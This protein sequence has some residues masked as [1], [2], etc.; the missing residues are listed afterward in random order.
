LLAAGAD[1]SSIKTLMVQS[2]KN[3][4]LSLLELT[5]SQPVV[6]DLWASWCLPC[7]Q[8]D[9]Y[10]EKIV[11]KYF[12]KFF[13]VKLSMDRDQE[14][15]L[16]TS[17]KYLIPPENGF[18]LPGNFES[19]FA[20]RFNISSIPRYILLDKDGKLINDNMPFPS[21]QEEFEKELKKA[22]H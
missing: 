11:K 3:D 7:R 18:L 6:I 8:Q 2:M 22:F 16:K 12:A 21:K 19:A 17:E 20:K 10:L 5:G 14:A 1:T 4:T 15:W 13:L 9:V